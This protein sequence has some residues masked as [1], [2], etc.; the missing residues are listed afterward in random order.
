MVPHCD[1]PAQAFI[2]CL[3]WPSLQPEPWQ[4]LSWRSGWRVTISA[5]VTEITCTDAGDSWASGPFTLDPSTGHFLSPLF[6][7]DTCS[8]PR[9]LLGCCDLQRH[10]S[11]PMSWWVHFLRASALLPRGTWSW[12]TVQTPA[13][14]CCLFG[15]GARAR[16][17]VGCCGCTIS[18]YTCYPLAY[19]SAHKHAP[20]SHQTAPTKHNFRDKRTKNFKTV[21]SRWSAKMGHFLAQGPVSLSH[22]P[23][24]PVL[25]DMLR[26]LFFLLTKNG[27]PWK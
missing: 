19:P 4:F 26:N 25:D 16:L 27:K 5:H 11:G 8:K 18:G 12:H 9:K 20:R 17:H 2:F 24:K 6:S 3:Y 10:Q 22:T 14:G 23:M 15:E 21:P 1:A 7:W 13:R